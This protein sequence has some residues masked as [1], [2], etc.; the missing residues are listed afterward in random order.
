MSTDSRWRGA[1]R[2]NNTALREADPN[3]PAGHRAR[4]R[5]RFEAAG[6]NALSDHELL[7]LLLFYAVPRR[8]TKPIAKRLLS[9]CHGFTGLLAPGA[10]TLEVPGVGAYTA[11][12]LRVIGAVVERRLRQGIVG[13]QMKL[14]NPGDLIAYLQAGMQGLRYEQLRV[15]F[16]DTL[17]RVLHDE[18]LTEGVED[19]TAVYPRLILRRALVHHATGVIMVHNHPAGTLQPSA[20]DREV[21]RAVVAAAEAVGMRVLDHIIVAASGQGYFSF[22]EAGLL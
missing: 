14:E 13:Q 6:A 12:F 2:P 3:S 11:T 9:M 21:T 17:N 10:P 5:Q 8:D 15:V 22:R 16:T 4:L 1:G 7:E 18:I 19:Q 20:A